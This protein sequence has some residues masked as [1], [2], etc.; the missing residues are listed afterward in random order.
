M[1]DTPTYLDPHTLAAV[2]G[3]ELRARMVVEG[4]MSGMH[5]SPY[6]GYSVEFA[7]HRQYAPGDDIRHLD[8]KVFGR[9]DKLYLKQYQKETNL[10][11]VIMVDVSGSMA[12]ESG[13]RRRDGSQYRGWRK[14]DYA[15]TLAAVLSNLAIKQQDRVGLIMFADEM[16]NATRTSS[17]RG[18]W[19]SIVEMLEAEPVDAIENDDSLV[20]ADPAHVEAR[21][22][23]LARLFDQV[24]ARLSQ[25]SLLVLISDLFDE[26]AALE[27]GLARVKHRGHDLFALQVLDHAELTFPYRSPS[28]FL[29]LEG[30][31]RLPLDPAAL[32]QAYLDT[33]H[34]HLDAVR[35][36]TRRFGFDHLLI[37]T[38]EQ[39]G[40]VLSHFLARRAA[41]VDK[42]K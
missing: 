8:W 12:F 1:P 41:I 29:G 5:R 20:G 23:S 39:L 15:A 30:E 38:S 7:Q 40:A 16:R 2:A 36:I 6:F 18:H 4:M 3:F 24:A 10:D 22:T 17:A 28:E 25:R 26:P 32:R 14:Y 34:E 9:S 33:L 42:R 13:D 27:R 35:E 19:R 31:G 21:A 11:L 37:D